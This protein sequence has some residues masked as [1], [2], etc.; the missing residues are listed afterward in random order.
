MDQNA[1]EKLSKR[2]W[3]LRRTADTGGGR[4]AY[5]FSPSE[6]KNAVRE[7]DIHACLKQLLRSGS[8]PHPFSNERDI[9][10]LAREIAQGSILILLRY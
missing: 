9:L 10:R 3:N 1:R 4:T 2:I 8:A 5:F 7:E 6:I